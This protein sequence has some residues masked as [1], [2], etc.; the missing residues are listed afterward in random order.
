MHYGKYLKNNIV[1]K[2]EQFYVDYK[3]LKK[4]IKNKNHDEFWKII[5]NEILKLNLV[6]NYFKEQNVNLIELN[7]FIILNYMAFFKTIK[8]YDKKLCKTTKILFFELIQNQSFYKEFLNQPRDIKNTKLVIFDKDGTL[9]HIEKIFIS[10]FLQFKENIK[11]SI[12]NNEEFNKFMGYDEINTN[13]LANSVIVKGTNDDIRNRILE[14]IKNTNKNRDEDNIRQYI[15]SKWIEI[16][17]NKDNIIEC[18]NT[19]K[20]FKKLKDENIKI[21]I[22]TSDDRLQTIK[23][24]K[25]LNLMKYIDYIVCGDDPISSKPSPE[26]IWKI[27]RELNINVSEAIMVGD[28]ISDIHAGLNAKCSNVYGVLTG[29]YNSHELQKADK[30][31]KSIDDIPN[32]LIKLN[33]NITLI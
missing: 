5:Q 33:N 4:N 20:V 31:L 9:I 2:W 19:S 21:A 3:L 15:K 16:E 26:P 7:Q 24:L 30:I 8:K 17:V 28:T 23:T 1:K 14:Y 25:I 10:W 29:G 32:N 18:G 22:C 11:D 12:V 27:C 6:I 13:F